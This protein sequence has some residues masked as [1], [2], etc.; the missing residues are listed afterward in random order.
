MGSQSKCINDEQHAGKDSHACIQQRIAFGRC[1][2]TKAYAGRYKI[3]PAQP[4]TS[5][6]SFG[7]I[8]FVYFRE[9]K[10]PVLLHDFAVL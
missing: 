5:L 8:R 6:T 1:A 9:A 2:E 7:Y 3:E 10:C 4:G